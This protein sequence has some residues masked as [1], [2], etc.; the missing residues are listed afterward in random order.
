MDHGIMC[1]G[2]YSWTRRIMTMWS[3]M[4]YSW[5]LWFCHFNKEAE[6]NEFTN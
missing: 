2:D 3:I 6:V 5:V 4:L 1:G